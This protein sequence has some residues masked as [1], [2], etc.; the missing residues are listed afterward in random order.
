QA[1]TLFFGSE[2]KA[3]QVHPQ[4]VTEL[5][6]DQV[7]EYLAFRYCAG[8]RHLIKTVNQLRP[9]HCLSFSPDGQV[10]IRRYY[11]IPDGP[12]QSGLSHDE[13]LDGLGQHLQ[14][15]VESQL[16][17]DVKV[18]CQLSGG[19]DSSLT[20]LYARKYFSADMDCFSIILDDPS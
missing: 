8:E 11:E 3:F 7:D 19:I 6:E 10:H 17:S 12:V 9:G 16:L 20:T 2:V 14:R 1:N 15:S 18:G 13:A 4:F 5:D